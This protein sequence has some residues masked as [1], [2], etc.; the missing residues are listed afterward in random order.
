MNKPST[1]L[2]T[3]K[4]ITRLPVK[5]KVKFGIAS[6]YTDRITSPIR[7]QS[8]RISEISPNISAFISPKL[9]PRPSSPFI[10]KRS[11][12]PQLGITGICKNNRKSSAK[13][14]LNSTEDTSSQRLLSNTN[15]IIYLTSTLAKSKEYLRIAINYLSAYKNDIRS[16][17]NEFENTT[18]LVDN[19]NIPVHK[20][21]ELLESVQRFYKGFEAVDGFISSLAN[22]S[23]YTGISSYHNENA[24]NNNNA[25]A[26]HD[27]RII[28]KIS[29]QSKSKSASLR[30]K[31][32]LILAYV[33]KKKLLEVNDAKKL[34]IEVNRLREEKKVSAR[35][36]EEID[37]NYEKEKKK[38]KDFLNRYNALM[39]KFIVSGKENTKLHIDNAE[40]ERRVKELETNKQ[41]EITEELNTLRQEHSLNLKEI[42]EKDKVIKKLSKEIRS[43]KN[44]IKRLLSAVQ[45]YKTEISKLLE[46]V[47]VK[48]LTIKELLNA[49][50][51]SEEVETLKSLIKQLELDKNNKQKEVLFLVNKISNIEKQFID[52]RNEHQ[53]KMKECLL[54]KEQK[55]ELKKELDKHLSSSVADGF[56]A[57]MTLANVILARSNGTHTITSKEKELIRNIFDENTKEMLEEI[58]K[59]QNEA[60]LYKDALRRLTNKQKVFLQSLN[61]ANVDLLN[62]YRKM[63]MRC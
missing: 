62:K 60:K 44:E 25:S 50:Y 9:K 30:N 31:F 48:Q 61:T 3:T 22:N 46:E 8:P 53:E 33:Y 57:L 51:K 13:P 6:P 41:L 45:D 59:Q 49:S 55:G 52:L 58:I 43:N 20:L 42:E 16:F 40:L 32:E 37:K 17:L 10:S 56:K 12:S 34:R 18:D 27:Q 14:K 29:E 28:K 2:I 39:K 36:N 4:G 63:Y 35:I 1:A 54:L 47:E 7:N 15:A 21:Q 11:I 38:S 19:T 5:F 23:E 26:L 24:S